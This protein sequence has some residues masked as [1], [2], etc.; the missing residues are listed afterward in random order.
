MK[1]AEGGA[2]FADTE[3]FGDY[4]RI[5]RRRYE[6][7]SDKTNST[8]Y[9]IYCGNYII[10]DNNEQGKQGYDDDNGSSEAACYKF[11]QRRKSDRSGAW[12]C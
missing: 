11:L 2:D 1:S 9:S 6:Q 10:W 12:L 7:K 8:C 5:I 4:D 3:D